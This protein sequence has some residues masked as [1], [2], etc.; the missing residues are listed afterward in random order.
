MARNRLVWLLLVLLPIGRPVAAED[1]RP[2]NI[3]LIILDDLGT[4]RVG[5]YGWPTAGPTP[6]LDE[7]AAEG[8]RFD[9]FWGS[10]HCSPFRASALTGLP[11]RQHE[12]SGPID[13]E[14]DRRALGLDPALDTLPKRL[15]PRGYRSEAL[16]KWHLA[17]EPDFTPR[18]PLLVGFDHHAGPLGNV[19]RTNSYE[20]FEKCVDGVCEYVTDRYLTS[21][22]TDDVIEALRGSE[23]FFLWVG[24]NAAHRP[25][26]VPP[27]ELHGFEGLDCPS[28]SAIRCHKALVESLDSELGRVFAAVDWRDT[29]VIVVADNGTPR[30]AL[31]EPSDSGGKGSV[32]ESGVRVPLIVRGAAVSPEAEGAVAV[33]LTQVEDL[34]ATLLELAGVSAESSYSRSFAQL[35]EDP[36]AESKRPWQYAERYTPNGPKPTSDRIRR[37]YQAAADDQFKVVIRRNERLTGEPE[38]Y[39]RS[40]VMERDDL[41]DQPLGEPERQALSRLLAVVDQEGSMRPLPA[42]PPP[43]SSE[44][45]IAVVVGGAGLLIWQRRRRG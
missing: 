17:G 11:V 25:F 31:D 41:T 21:D 7:L 15:A 28:G 1:P 16:G 36:A 38:L 19:G 5:A 26:H 30:G 10:P 13:R 39:K 4:E 14:S 33:G 45:L 23:P 8:V 20:S 24:Y 40:D 6:N 9:N 22:T 27:R 2:Q 44:W 3:V 43:R 32:Y 42:G 37:H 34:F 29:T 35:L 18:H 12:I